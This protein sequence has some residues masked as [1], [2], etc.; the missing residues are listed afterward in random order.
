VTHD[1]KDGKVEEKDEARTPPWLFEY[2][3]ERHHFTMD[4]ATNGT[5]ALCKGYISKSPCFPDGFLDPEFVLYKDESGYCNPPYSLHKVDQFIQKCYLESLDGP[6]I[7]MLLPMDSSTA[8]FH[9]F[10]MKAQKWYLFRPRIQFLRPDG[11]PMPGSPKFGSFA[12]VFDEC[13]RRSQSGPLV[14]SVDVRPL[15]K[16]WQAKMKGRVVV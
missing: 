16:A 3:N 10:C 15:K 14:E 9:R 7:T 1:R 11:T 2:L 13:G 12:C 4:L 8:A 6:V 5:N